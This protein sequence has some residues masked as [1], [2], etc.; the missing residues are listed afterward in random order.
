MPINPKASMLTSGQSQ[1]FTL[2]DRNGAPVPAGI[3]W[4]VN[5]AVGGG[6]IDVTGLYTAPVE[7]TVA[8]D[9]TVSGQSAGGAAAETA[10]VRLVPPEVILVPTKVVLK[11][12]ESQ[13]FD[14]SVRG[15]AATAVRWNI[16]PGLG[17]MI[18]GLYSAPAAITEDSDVQVTATSAIDARKSA[19]AAIRLLSKPPRLILAIGLLIYLIAIFCLVFLLMILW[20][21]GL[22]DRTNF[23]KAKSTRVAAES[24]ADTARANEK[25]ALAAQKEAEDLLQKSPNDASLKKQADAA[26]ASVKGAAAV[27]ATA[28]EKEKTAQDDEKA[29]E[30]RVR[31]SDDQPIQT[32]WFEPMSREVNLLLLVLVMGALGS[33]VYSARSFVDFVGNRSLR[34]SWSAWY[35]MYPLIGSALALVFYLAIRGGFLTPASKG[36]EVN[37]YGLMAISGLV[38]MFSKQATTKLA[39]LFTTLF[40]TDKDDTKLKDKLS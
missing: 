35:L 1:Q 22:Y 11:A 30:A 14:A 26:A 15:D 10:S 9:V 17:T 5:P 23:E 33:F 16:A 40:K 25:K 31:A 13:R 12:G 36:A 4:T 8:A 38:G 20:P 3:T 21:P 18:D 24:A 6:S 34:A 27:R 2:V 7:V 39:E 37:V 19:T 28:E 29:E 32:R